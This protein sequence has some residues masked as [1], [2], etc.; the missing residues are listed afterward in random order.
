M[1]AK[2]EDGTLRDFEIARPPPRSQAPADDPLVA[3]PVSW[4]SRIGGVGNAISGCGGT[5]GDSMTSGSG[6]SGGGGSPRAACDPEGFGK[7]P[8]VTG[9]NE[10]KAPGRMCRRVPMVTGLDEAYSPS[11]RVTEDQ[12][13]VAATACAPHPAR[14]R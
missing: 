2:A 3:A 6:R 5:V 11:N 7:A 14:L 12:M 10:Q 13:Q 8:P 9:S 1:P 4:R